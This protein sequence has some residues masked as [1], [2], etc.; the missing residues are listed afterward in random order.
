MAF[1]IVRQMESRR[2]AQIVSTDMWRDELYSSVFRPR[3][4]RRVRRA[5]LDRVDFLI[6]AGDCVIHDDTNY[7][8]SM[9]H[10]LLSVAREHGC[11]FAVVHVTTPLQ[12]ALD[13]N[14]TRSR[15]IPE[16]VILRI[17]DRFDVPGGRYAWD[18]PIA[19]V[20]L[21][22]TDAWDAAAGIVRSLAEL[23]PL[24]IDRPLP[25]ESIGQAID[26]VTRRVVARFLRENTL[27]QR[28]PAVHRLRKTVLREAREEGLSV[29]EARNR[30]NRRL[31]ELAR[32]VS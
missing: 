29:S 4:E 26:L 31:S 19:S 5:A 20:N 3:N 9:R 8:A 32:A 6:R 27:F 17:A 7:Y 16:H 12:V 13:W 15:P 1:E 18:R 21:A 28:D 24:R 30:L 11:A 22:A 2:R 10:E 23:E 25:G 14:L